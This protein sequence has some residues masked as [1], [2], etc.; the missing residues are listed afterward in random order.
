MTVNCAVLVGYRSAQKQCQLGE[1][2][3]RLSEGWSCKCGIGIPIDLH[4]A[5]RLHVIAG[6]WCVL[7]PLE[8]ICVTVIAHPEH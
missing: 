6:V 8:R 2:F 7:L 5:V 3:E 4:I 1:Y